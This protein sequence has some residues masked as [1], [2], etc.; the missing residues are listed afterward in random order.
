MT[1]FTAYLENLGP[2]AIE[3]ITLCV[4]RP[5]GCAADHRDVVEPCRSAVAV[6]RSVSYFVEHPMRDRRRDR[7]EGSRSTPSGDCAASRDP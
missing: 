4:R 1:A 2:E 7:R 6:L 5:D 3:S